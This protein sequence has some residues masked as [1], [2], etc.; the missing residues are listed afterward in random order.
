VMHFKLGPPV[1]N[2]PTLEYAGFDWNKP[3][4]SRRSIYRLVFRN[5]VD[6]FMAALDFPDAAQLAPTRPFSA[7]S[8]QAL[9]LWND[10]FIL[11]QSEKVA[12]RVEKMGGGACE[13]IR[14]SVKL[15]LLRDSPIGEMQA[16]SAYAERHGL[17]AT[18]RVLLN[19][20][21]FLFVD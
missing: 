2:T 4:V 6:P 11:R 12:T 10:A 1:Q 8:I 20:N 13:Q 19:T 3:G 15:I 7:S 17:A 14:N 18:C 5:I 16:L 9:A 21:E